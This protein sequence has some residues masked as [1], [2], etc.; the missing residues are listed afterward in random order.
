MTEPAARHTASSE[1]A[2]PRSVTSHVNKNI[3]FYESAHA[4]EAETRS[5]AARAHSRQS[6]GTL[7]THHNHANMH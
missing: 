3:F 1:R 6:S 4:W 2:L 5:T 7:G